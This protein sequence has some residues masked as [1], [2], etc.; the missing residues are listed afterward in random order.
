M[1][2]ACVFRRSTRICGNCKGRGVVITFL[3]M[4]QRWAGMFSDSELTVTPG[5]IGFQLSL[6]ADFSTSWIHFIVVV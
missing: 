3:K 1:V 6:Q 4:V 5:V 2:R